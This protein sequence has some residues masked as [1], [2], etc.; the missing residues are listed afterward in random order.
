MQK[1]LIIALL[2]LVGAIAHNVLFWATDWGINTLLFGL[3]LIGIIAYAK[4]EVLRFRYARII[5]IGVLVSGLMVTLHHH[6]ISKLVYAL[7]VFLLIG[8]TQSREIRFLYYGSLLSLS[9]F[10]GVP[11][12]FIRRFQSWKGFGG[13]GR[14]LFYW[15]KIALIPM[16]IT[17]LFFAIYSAA[18]PKFA[19]LFEDSLIW[20]ENLLSYLGEWNIGRILFFL[21]G[22][23]LILAIV[24]SSIFQ[25]FYATKEAANRFPLLRQK[26]PR[27]LRN[28]FHSTLALKSEYR[29]AALCLGLLNVLL[30][31]VNTV[32][33]RFVW[34]DY[35]NFSAPELKQFVHTGTYMLILAIFMAM[36]VL[37]YFF[38]K[39]LNFYPNNS[40]LKQLAY[41]WIIQNG[42]LAFSVGVRNYHYVHHY[43]L[44]Y[45][46]IGVV[47]F[48][49]LVFYG[50]WTFFQKIHT[51]KTIYY[52]LFRNS[53][54]VYF[55]FLFMTFFNWDSL[56][57]KYNIHAN[58][59]HGIGV[60]YLV[61]QLS[62]S[63]IS[64][65]EANLE[66]LAKHDE[67]A[68]VIVPEKRRRFNSKIKY[69]DWRAWN[70]ADARNKKSENE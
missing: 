16:M 38:R 42:I 7:S 41:A 43:G 45:K 68:I 48:L 66:E 15:L 3:V 2:T 60:S 1:E 27:P 31:L 50:L 35:G 44:T 11:A 55:A 4:P 24:W 39:N 54:A 61:H 64:L 21:F 58:T 18:S 22:L 62:D 53:W 56:I 20:L 37:L 13:N 63:N 17:L 32:D 12:N 8:F 9:G 29:M 30:F 34:L 5:A 10:F 25:D 14:Q 52:L 33:L 70:W 23:G 46:R 19:E 40:L 51:R 49:C 69:Q 36:G 47:V 26:S 28:P 67:N 57:T 65:L 59:V 6:F